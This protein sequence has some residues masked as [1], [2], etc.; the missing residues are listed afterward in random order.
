MNETGLVLCLRPCGDSSVSS[1]FGCVCT[2]TAWY[3]NKC[4][5]SEQL[6]YTHPCH[7]LSTLSLAQQQDPAMATYGGGSI[8]KHLGFSPVTRTLWRTHTHTRAL[9]LRHTRP[10]ATSGVGCWRIPRFSLLLLREHSFWWRVTFKSS[11]CLVLIQKAL[12]FGSDRRKRNLL[13]LTG[14]I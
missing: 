14:P 13:L 6:L 12:A 11:R 1:L 2:M 10:A 4:K 9:S 8:S 7:L 5:H 3:L